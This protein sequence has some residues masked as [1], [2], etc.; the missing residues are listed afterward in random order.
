M[1]HGIFYLGVGTVTC[2]TRVS[3]VGHGIF[4]LGVGTVTCKT[5]VSGGSRNLLLGSWDC[6][7]YNKGEWWVTESFTWELGLLRVQQG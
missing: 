3:G 6:Y 1:G 5:R 2:T 4:Y 7:V